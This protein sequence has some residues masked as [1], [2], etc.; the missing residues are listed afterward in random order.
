MNKRNTSLVI[1]FLL[2]G[3]HLGLALLAPIMAP[4]S[5]TGLHPGETLQ[6]PSVKYWFGSDQYGRDVFSRV[7]VGSRSVV[8][9]AGAAAV[10]GMLLGSVIGLATGYYGG[11]ID[12][13][14]MRAMDILM[15]FPPLLTALLVLS[16]LGS[17][18][19]NVV[20]AIAIAST[21]RVA[22][23]VR[24]A[25]LEIKTREF[26]LAARAIGA[27]DRRII[28]RHLLPNASGPL[29]VEAAIRF[30]Y[31]VLAVGSLGFLGLGVQPPDPNWGLQIAE[32]RNF[33]MVAPWVII[34]PALAI[35]TLVLGVNLLADGLQ[36]RR[37]NNFYSACRPLIKNPLVNSVIKSKVLLQKSY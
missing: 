31:A 23:V 12:E 1:G 34:F 25:V 15:S 29:L 33:I 28:I 10:L 21:P 8:L 2:V 14:V 24:S 13:V 22:R 16:S 11:W 37:I 9:V 3:I 26:V 4:H 18:P 27:D 7:L 6:S 17:A 5:P 19:G 35:S 32:G 20:L 36:V 30:T